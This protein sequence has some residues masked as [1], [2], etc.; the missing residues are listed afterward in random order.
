MTYW[1]K[2]K[3][4]TVLKNIKTFPDMS[5]KEVNAYVLAAWDNFYTQWV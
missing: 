5:T 1:K 2:Q 4:H 3:E